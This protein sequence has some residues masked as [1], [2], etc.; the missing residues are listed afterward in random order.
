MPYEVIKFVEGNNVQ[1]SRVGGLPLLKDA[2][3]WP[4]HPT[5]GKPLLFLASI[6]GDFFC[7]I[8][9]ELIIPNGYCMSLFMCFDYSN[10]TCVREVCVHE[11]D[12]IDKFANGSTRVLIHKAGSPVEPPPEAPATLPLM[13]MKREYRSEEDLVPD[14]PDSGTMYSKV[15]GTPAWA[16]D[17]IEIPDH[18]FA[19]Q[20]Y[21]AD[22]VAFS[23]SHAE[24][25]AGGNGFL[26]LKPPL[27]GGESGVFFIQFT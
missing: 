6:T 24:L 18:I 9:P 4:R 25:F 12:Q 20:L 15:G 26:F 14:L 16:Q 13:L 1:E 17:V 21:E 3:D 23:P 7:N 8:F 19:L 2:A 27:Q 5:T 22:I 10:R 11:Q